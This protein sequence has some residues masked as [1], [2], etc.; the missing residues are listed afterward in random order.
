MWFDDDGPKICLHFWIEIRSFQPLFGPYTDEDRQ[1]MTY[2]ARNV[3]F[4]SHGNDA[5]SGVAGMKLTF[6]QVQRRSNQWYLSVKD[7]ALGRMFTFY[8]YAEI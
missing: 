2:S 7:E 3:R 5:P 8:Q 6:S 4:V 1:L